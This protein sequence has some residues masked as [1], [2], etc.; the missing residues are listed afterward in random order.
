MSGTR[1][2]IDDANSPSFE[3][4]AVVE[5]F[6][7]SG[8]NLVAAETAAGVRRHVALSIVGT[9]RTLDNG[10]V[11]AEVAQEKLI[12][13]SRIPYTIVRSAQFLDL[14]ARGIRGGHERDGTDD[15]TRQSPAGRPTRRGY[16]STE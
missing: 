12:E 10:Y 6:E 3:Y 2:V 13:K 1:V 5:F 4:R 15:P 9:D 7:T 14:A 8:R 16:T 11:R